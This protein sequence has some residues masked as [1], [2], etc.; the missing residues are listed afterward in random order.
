MAC[1]YS[2]LFHRQ[3]SPKLP[4]PLLESTV[5]LNTFSFKPRRRSLLLSA[6]TLAGLAATTGS[7]VVL[8]QAGSG[9]AP[10]TSKR[11]LFVVSNEVKVGPAGFPIGYWLAEIAHPFW[12]FQ[13]KGFSMVVASPDGGAVMQD[14]MSDPEGGRF[15]PPQDFLATGFKHSPRIKQVMSATVKL[16]TIKESDFDAILV[17]GGL[18]PMLTFADNTELHQLFARFYEAGKVS[19]ALCHGTVILLKTRL[20]NGALLAEGKQWTG[21]CNVEED[22]VDKAF[23]T[24]VQPFR[25]ED[26]AKKIANT[27]FVQGPPYRPFAVR[28]G[29][30]ITGQQGSS[31]A[32]TAE[33]VIEALSA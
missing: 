27:R 32:R 18:G 21:F 28:D 9:T 3:N 11:I 26:E 12:A 4:A 30:L 19:A 25:I 1:I 7:Q 17:V 10:A 8:A 29:R 31:G 24:K 2:M 15:G 16:S 5:S 20:A 6:A 23:N 13:Q 22:A 33:L 14:A